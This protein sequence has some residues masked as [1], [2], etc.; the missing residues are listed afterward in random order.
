M[1]P[2][3]FDH[4]ADVLVIGSGAAAY[5]AAIT[6]RSK[7]AE[8]ILVEKAPLAGGTTLRSGGGFWTPNNKFQREK[9]VADLKDDAV[10][11]MARYSF[12]QLYDPAEPMLGLP[13][14]S[15]T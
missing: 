4:E 8:V 15:T 5:S 14:M 10:R 7:G 3:A 9:G 12:P 11:Y 1:D 2:K 13:G 6:A